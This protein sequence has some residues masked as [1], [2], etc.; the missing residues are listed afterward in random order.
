M[1]DRLDLNLC[2]ISKSFVFGKEYSLYE[3]MAAI[4]AK[5][6]E[7]V[8]RFNG[9]EYINNGK[10][11]ILDGGYFNVDDKNNYGGEVI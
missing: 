11:T 5:V 7:L 3:V 8:Y 1:I 2:N 10:K 4:N 6:S 9:G